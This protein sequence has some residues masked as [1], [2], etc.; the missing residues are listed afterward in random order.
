MQSHREMNPGSHG[1]ETCSS[2]F[3]ILRTKQIQ[4]QEG[5]YDIYGSAYP[6]TNVYSLNF[7]RESSVSISGDTATV[8]W[9]TRAGSL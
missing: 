5:V 7:E 9:V 6:T 2:M 1:Q 4:Q 8:T 3:Q